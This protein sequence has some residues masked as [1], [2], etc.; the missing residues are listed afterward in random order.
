MDSESPCGAAGVAP[1][2][3]LP[4]GTFRC[5]QQYPQQAPRQG[6]LCGVRRGRVVLEAGRNFEQALRDLDGFAKIWLIYVFDRNTNWKPL[7]TPPRG[8]GKRG[9]FAT[10]APHRPNPIGLS[11]VTL[12]GVEGRELVVE[13]FD[14][15]D[16]TPILDIKP[17]LAYADSF[18][19]AS[20]G[21]LAD[22]EQD[23]YELSLSE[24]AA[25]KITW[26][27]EHAGYDIGAFIVSQLSEAPLDDRRKRISAGGRGRYVIA[28][29]TWRIH[30]S[31][32]EGTRR[33]SVLELA[34]GYS[35]ADLGALEDRYGDK[36]V[37]QAFYR[38][39]GQSAAR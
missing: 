9:V 27:T 7:V 3:L 8:E 20:A 29:R 6:T 18:P 34:S 31:V 32:D 22:A 4:I 25:R 5:D 36:P 39:F 11:C 1:L 17:Y 12:V 2:Q 15:L 30:Y 10:R 21:W 23:R 24:T 35:E 37:H 38:R 13:D 33:V 26:I 14:L 16:G 19:E 28:A